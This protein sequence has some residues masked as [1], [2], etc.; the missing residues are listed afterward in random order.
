L[1]VDAQESVLA[2]HCEAA[3]LV[4]GTDVPID[5]KTNDWTLLRDQFAGA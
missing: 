1:E 3:K 5:L 4:W 2:A